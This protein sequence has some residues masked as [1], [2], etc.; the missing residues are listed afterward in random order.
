M[1]SSVSLVVLL[2]LLAA[3]LA[4]IFGRP[5]LA[6]RREPRRLVTDD[7]V[8][9]ETVEAA[10]EEVRGLDAFAS[11]QDAEEELP[12]WGPGAPKS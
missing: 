11:P 6:R 10:E 2:V 4:W 3:L 7:G 5:D 9:A 12:D 1:S 8:D